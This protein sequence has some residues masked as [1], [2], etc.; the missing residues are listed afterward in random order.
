MSKPVV[1]FD[2]DGFLLDFLTPALE[3]ANEVV[4]ERDYYWGRDGVYHHTKTR[5]PFAP[6][7][8]ESF[9]TWDIFD[10]IGREYEAACYREY[11]KKGFCAS[12]KPYPEAVDGVR[13]ARE[14][15]DVVIVTSPMHSPTW[16]HERKL[17]L[18]KHFDIPAKDVI[19]AKRKDLVVGRMLV[20]DNPQHVMEWAEAHYPKGQGVLWSMPYNADSLMV[21]RPSYTRY[22]SSW[23]ALLDLIEIL[24]Y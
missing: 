17:S 3:V 23:P 12:I 21:G 11:E 16:C 18:Q 24:T 1:L 6:Y 19:F 15:A 20:D 10:T 7:T 2:A 9:K 22:V 4:R 8:P 14:M 5:A 13:K